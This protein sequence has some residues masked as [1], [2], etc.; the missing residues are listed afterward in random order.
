MSSFELRV[1]VG[2]IVD[3]NLTG[4]SHYSIED[5]FPGFAR[6]VIVIEHNSLLDK[7]PDYESC[8]GEAIGN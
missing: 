8:I 7:D 5:H 6:A 1:K 4:Y 3:R 2:E